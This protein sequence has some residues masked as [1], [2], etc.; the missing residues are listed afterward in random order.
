MACAPLP[1]DPGEL[2]TPSRG[3]VSI[4]VKKASMGHGRLDPYQKP[5]LGPPGA[6]SCG[7]KQEGG[8]QPHP[9]ARPIPHSIA[10]T[11][12]SLYPKTSHAISTEQSQLHLRLLQTHFHQTAIKW[13]EQAV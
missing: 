3:L 6:S 10:L 1:P 9:A 12:K 7:G 13:N 4:T 5:Q 2:Q 11:I 8:G